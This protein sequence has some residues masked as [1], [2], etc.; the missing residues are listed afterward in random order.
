MEQLKLTKD[1]LPL[2]GCLPMLLQLPI[3][4][5]L[6]N[7]ITNPLSSVYGYGKEALQ[8]LSEVFTANVHLFPGIK[9]S[10]TE[11]DAISLHDYEGHESITPEHWRY[12]FG[13]IRKV[14]AQV[15]DDA[16]RVLGGTSLAD[17]AAFEL[18]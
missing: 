4:M 9:A 11:T 17:A 14:M 8:K 3:I 6:Y 7:V 15:R 16:V 18:A 1:A 12:K 2:G 10:I 13:A 5:V